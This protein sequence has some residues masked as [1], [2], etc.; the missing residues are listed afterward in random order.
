MHVFGAGK[1]RGR[2]V[3]C[4]FLS[5]CRFVWHQNNGSRF[6]SEPLIGINSFVGHGLFDLG[7]KKKEVRYV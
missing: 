2:E 7:R 4:T 3:L 6:S 5:R 1:F